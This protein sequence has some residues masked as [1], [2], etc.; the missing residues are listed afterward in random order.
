MIDG[1]SGSFGGGSAGSHQ[2]RLLNYLTEEAALMRKL[3]H[4]NVPLEKKERCRW[5]LQ[6][7]QTTLIPQSQR[8]VL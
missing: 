5:R 3:G 8:T 4:P 1:G 6:Q 2:E 7:L